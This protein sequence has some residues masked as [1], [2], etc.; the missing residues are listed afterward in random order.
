MQECIRLGIYEDYKEYIISY[1][2]GIVCTRCLLFLFRSRLYYKYNSELYKYS[3]VL[4]DHLQKIEAIYPGYTSKILES[5]GNRHKRKLKLFFS[6][7]GILNAWLYLKFG[8]KNLFH[9]IFW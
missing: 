3:S 9:K 6:H 1:M 2:A 4:N 5:F 7:P 8:A